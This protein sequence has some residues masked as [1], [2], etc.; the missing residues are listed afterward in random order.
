M[1]LILKLRARVSPDRRQI[2]I[3]D[4]TGNYNAE[5]NPDGWGAPNYEKD[6]AAPTLLYY[7][8]IGVIFTAWLNLTGT[9]KATS[10]YNGQEVS[11]VPS[12]FGYAVG[13]DMFPEGEHTVELFVLRDFVDPAIDTTNILVDVVTGNRNITVNGGSPIPDLTRALQPR[14][15]LYSDAPADVLSPLNL[16]DMA[17]PYTPTTAVLQRNYDYDIDSPI[18]LYVVIPVPVTLSVTDGIEQ[19]II[20]TIGG[21]ASNPVAEDPEVDR[22]VYMLLQKTAMDLQ[23]ACG[24]LAAAE[25]IRAV[26][27]H[28]CGSKCGCS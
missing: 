12:D 21:V 20:D 28:M 16:I 8:R 10:L 1:A 7:S 6:A 23:I 14:A 19:C 27:L 13:V 3:Q 24:N 25:D 22:A 4:N 18:P 9:A 26:L 17:E 2:I 5:T 15:G 11:F